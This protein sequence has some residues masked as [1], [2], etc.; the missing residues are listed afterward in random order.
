VRALSLLIAGV[1]VLGACTG[2]LGGGQDQGDCCGPGSDAI[3]DGP[4]GG[5]EGS[6][7]SDRA[8]KLEPGSKP[9]DTQSPGPAK[10]FRASSLWNT[11]IANESVSWADEP[12]LRSGSWWVNWD[13]YSNPVVISKSSDP[14]VDV[15][16]PS[17]WGWPA[18]T[19]KLRIPAGVT[20]AAGTDASL[21][22]VDGT[23]VYDF[24]QFTRNSSTGSASAY[25]KNDVVTGS[26]WGSMSPSKVG[27]GIRAAG[28]SG[29]AGEIYGNELT[30]GIFHALA[31]ASTSDAGL[32]G[33]TRPPAVSSDGPAEATR[34]GIPPGTS[35]PGGLSV[36]GSKVWDALQTYGAWLVDRTSGASPCIFNADPRSVPKAD[37]DA[38]LADLDK[39]TPSIRVVV[40]DYP[41][42][43]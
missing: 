8:G 13:S 36:Q 40:H 41:F 19:L 25:A 23:T 18:G 29:L 26:G 1:L 15:T 16:V 21:V 43:P 37:I 30:Q 35:K 7:P 24:W 4:G 33:P 6:G 2:V 17:S 9:K 39:I 10:F 12:G 5:G 32:D 20:G 11:P 14:Q 27:A 28:S 38:L 31:F 3:F 42:N 34:V 22:I